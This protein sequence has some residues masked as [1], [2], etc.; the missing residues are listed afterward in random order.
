MRAFC[1]WSAEGAEP[2]GPAPPEGS[3]SRGAS[4][5]DRRAVDAAVVALAELAAEDRSDQR[6]NDDRG[7]GDDAAGRDV[8]RVERDPRQ[9]QVLE[10]GVLVAEDRARRRHEQRDDQADRPDA[11]AL[12]TAVEARHPSGD[13]AAAV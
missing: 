7:E 1:P 5:D 12:A 11:E 10:H 9:G 4:V 13:V 6:R 3:V 8:A 2:I